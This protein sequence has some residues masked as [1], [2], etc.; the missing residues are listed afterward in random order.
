MTAVV[1]LGLNYLHTGSVTLT[2]LIGFEFVTLTL[3]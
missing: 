2:F 1:A 3:P